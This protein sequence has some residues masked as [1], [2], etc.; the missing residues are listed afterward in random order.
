MTSDLVY[1]LNFILPS[2]LLKPTRKKI[3]CTCM[4]KSIFSPKETFL[5]LTPKKRFF[6][7]QKV[8]YVYAFLDML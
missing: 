3:F 2:E 7:L 1:C 6:T 4:E 8:S 5:I